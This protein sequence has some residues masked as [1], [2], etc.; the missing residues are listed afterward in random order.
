MKIF[1]RSRSLSVSVLVVVTLSSRPLY[2]FLF[3]KRHC[4]FAALFPFPRTFPRLHPS[5]SSFRS[6]IPLPCYSSPFF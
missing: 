5:I 4:T 6:L 1:P 2:F 3:I